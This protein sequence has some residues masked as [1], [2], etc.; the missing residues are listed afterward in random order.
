MRD[1]RFSRLQILKP[2]SS[3]LRRHVMLW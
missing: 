3:G 1:F 2:R